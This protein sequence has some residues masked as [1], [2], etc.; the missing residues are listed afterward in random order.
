MSKNKKHQPKHENQPTSSLLDFE[1]PV[2][3][4]KNGELCLNI[5][6]KPGAKDTE[7]ASIDED[8]I[9]VKIGAPPVDGEANKELIKFISKIIG[10]KSSDVFLDK[11]S[12]N[13]NKI[14]ILSNCK[15]NVDEIMEL[16]KKETQI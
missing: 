5:F 6:A 9:N 1:K 12:K 4:N 10:L 2:F 7:I 11:G 8:A 3:L 16:M 15:L 13:R 14:L